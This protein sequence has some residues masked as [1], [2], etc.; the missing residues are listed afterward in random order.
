MHTDKM[1]CNILDY[2]TFSQV[3]DRTISIHIFSVS[4]DFL[5]NATLTINIT[6]LLL[7]NSQLFDCQ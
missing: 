5:Q 4:V 6:F 2:F 3:M 1:V 7:F